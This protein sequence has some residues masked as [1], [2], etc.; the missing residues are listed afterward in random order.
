MPPPY[1][2]ES[3]K[4]ENTTRHSI[5]ISLHVTRPTKS[6]SIAALRRISGTIFHFDMSGGAPPPSSPLVMVAERRE[7]FTGHPT[8]RARELFL[9]VVYVQGVKWT[10]IFPLLS[11]IHTLF[12]EEI[13]RVCESSSE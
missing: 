4:L 6:L 10:W 1:G 13:H 12:K 8:D 3:A 2:G 11:I 9:G 5:E 7:I